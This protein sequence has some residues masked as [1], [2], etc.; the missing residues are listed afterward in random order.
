MKETRIEYFDWANEL[1]EEDYVTIGEWVQENK[2]KILQCQ[3]VIKKSPFQKELEGNFYMWS[4]STKYWSEDFVCVVRKDG[5]F[6]I[7]QGYGNLSE[8]KT[9]TFN[10]GEIIF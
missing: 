8:G 6:L 2:Q 4:N 10:I 7:C 9:T 1:D 3:K 5:V